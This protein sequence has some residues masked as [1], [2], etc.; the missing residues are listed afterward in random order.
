M[1]KTTET[2]TI[3][4]DTEAYEKLHSVQESLQKILHKRKVSFSQAVK[5]LFLCTRLDDTLI[6]W[7]LEGAA[8]PHEKDAE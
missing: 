7:Q 4:I 1:A 6:D 8:T 3:E 2:T 5:V